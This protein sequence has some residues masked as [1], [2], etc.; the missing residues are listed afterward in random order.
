MNTFLPVLDGIFLAD[1]HLNL[2][3]LVW[4]RWVVYLGARCQTK[5][6][7]DDDFFIFLP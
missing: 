3:A 7:V 6:M 1:P 5:T 4:P 2:D